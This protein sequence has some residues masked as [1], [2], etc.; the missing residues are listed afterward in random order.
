M[1]L[2]EVHPRTV[3]PTERSPGAQNLDAKSRGTRNNYERLRHVEL[4]RVP[5]RHAALSPLQLTNCLHRWRKNNRTDHPTSYPYTLMKTGSE[6]IAVIMHRR[7]VLFAVFVPCMEDTR[8]PKYVI[9]GELVGGAGW[10]G[11]KEK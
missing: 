1:Q 5:L 6:N 10:V 11:E 4:A 8:L 3:R 2:P 7:R 9:F